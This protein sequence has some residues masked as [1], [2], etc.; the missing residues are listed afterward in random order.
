MG[1][2]RPAAQLAEVDVVAVAARDVARAERF[3]RRHGIPRVHS[4]YDALLDDSEIDAVYNPLPNGLHC[5]WTLRALEAGKH[6]LCEKPIASN[7]DEAQRMATAADKSGRVLIEAFHYRYHPLAARIRE[8]L[9]GGELGA[10]RHVESMMCIPLAVPGDIRYRLDLAGGATMDVGSYTVNLLRFLSGEE[11]EVV[12]ASAKLSSTDV[13]RRMD[14]DFRFPNGA[15]GRMTCSMF[16]AKLLSI[17]ARVVGEK[18]E[19]RILNPVAP[20]IYH[21]LRVIRDG[22]TQRERVKGDSTY[23]H[24]LRAFAAQLAG[25]PPMETDAA[26]GVANMRVIDAVYAAA[27]LPRRAAPSH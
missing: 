24:Q 27:G 12:R 16:S 22:V 4:S 5:D 23:T 25:G 21:Q 11:P 14:A 9:D 8:I 15:T 13:D 17:R 2:I 1:V 3:A 10:I 26:D 19:L 20:H 7:A 18:G 6:V